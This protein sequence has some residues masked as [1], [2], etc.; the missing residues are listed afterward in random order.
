LSDKKELIAAHRLR[1]TDYERFD[2][3]L[4]Q[5][6]CE[7]WG[8]IIKDKM[9]DNWHIRYICDELQKWAKSIFKREPKEYDIIINIPPGESK[10]TI[11]SVMFPAWLWAIDPSLQLITVSYNADLSIDLSVKS[12]DVISSDKYQILYGSKYKIRADQDAKFFYKN[13]AGGWRL[14]TSVGAK[15]TGYHAHVKIMDDGNNPNDS[16]NPELFDKDSVWYDQ[17]FRNRNVEEASTLELFVQQ[18]VSINDMTA[19]ILSKEKKVIKHIKIPATTEYDI[20][21]ANLIRYYKNGLMNPLRR[22]WDVMEKLISDMGDFFYAAQ[23]GQEPSKLGGGLVKEENFE[24]INA[25]DLPSDFWSNPVYYFVDSAFKDKQK[26]DPSGILVV[27]P[28]NYCIY[29]LDFIDERLTYLKLKDRLQEIYFEYSGSAANSLM[30]VEEASSGYA[31]IEELKHD[32]PVNVLA[33][34]KSNDSKY[35]R[36]SACT[37]IIRGGKIKLIEDNF[38]GRSWNKKYKEVLTKFPNV[39]HDEAVDVTVMAIEELIKV[40]RDFDVY[41][42]KFLEV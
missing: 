21:P 4:Y 25:S 24:M 6:V 22:G 27:I 35:A 16:A 33:Y 7:F 9:Q 26:N 30:V 8:V 31:I 5:F 13:S 37:N 28:Y 2:D 19:H 42:R 15:V 34:P 38:A 39:P 10:S 32:T 14:A 18:R 36:F 12:K 29:V 41:E 3:A 11:C 23:Y 20:K 17:V 1:T 40:E